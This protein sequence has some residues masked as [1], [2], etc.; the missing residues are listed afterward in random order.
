M[1]KQEIV[2][3]V[4]INEAI[5]GALHGCLYSVLE[6]APFVFQD[7]QQLLLHI[8]Q[9]LDKTGRPQSSYKKRSF[10]EEPDYGY[11][12]LPVKVQSYEDFKDI[13][14]AIG[15]FFIQIV[16]RHNGAW[17]GACILS[18][19]QCYEFHSDLELLHI[20]EKLSIVNGY[21]TTA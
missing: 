16:S 21:A 6:E 14:G 5:P 9:V 11:Q 13:E 20:F 18:N 1:M 3:K 10:L 19:Q 4:C 17:Q 7:V 8:D 12:Y 15:T 2:F